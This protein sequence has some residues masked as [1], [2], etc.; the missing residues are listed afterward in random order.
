MDIDT[1][2]GTYQVVS[3]DKRIETTLTLQGAFISAAFRELADK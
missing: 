3:P 1:Y 2:S